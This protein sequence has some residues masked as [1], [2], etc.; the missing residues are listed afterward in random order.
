VRLFDEQEAPAAFRV[1]ANNH[2]PPCVTR[3]RKIVHREA[4]GNLTLLW[5]IDIR[6]IDHCSELSVGFFVACV[7]HCVGVLIRT[8]RDRLVLFGHIPANLG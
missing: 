8:L 4:F 2:I 3:T 5:T 7:E 1:R 6:G